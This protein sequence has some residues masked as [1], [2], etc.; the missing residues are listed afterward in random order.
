MGDAVLP[1]RGNQIGEATAGAVN[2][3]ERVSHRWRAPRRTAAGGRR[4]RRLGPSRRA[5]ASQ[6]AAAGCRHCGD[7]DAGDFG[8]AD[9]AMLLDGTAVPALPTLDSARRGEPREA[10]PPAGPNAGTPRGAMARHG[11]PVLR[12]LRSERGAGP[13]SAVLP[14]AAADCPRCRHRR[15]AASRAP[16]PLQPP[17]MPRLASPPPSPPPPPSSSSSVASPR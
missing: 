1:Q 2:G 8:D 15:G 5:R 16:Q 14:A 4:W 10:P 9:E 3:D 17:S 12:R 6:S 13:T 7:G 11:D